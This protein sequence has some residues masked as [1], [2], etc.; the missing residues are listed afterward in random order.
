MKQVTL[1]D[2]DKIQSLKSLYTRLC[3][4]IEKI[5]KQKRIQS[6]MFFIENESEYMQEFFTLEEVM[7]KL[8]IKKTSI[9]KQLRD[10]GISL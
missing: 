9:E 1:N 7:S 3:F 6:V 8:I 10:L 5:K 2:I 4:F